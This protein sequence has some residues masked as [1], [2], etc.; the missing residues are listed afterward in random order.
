MRR[1][2]ILGIDPGERWLGVARAAGDNRLAFPLGSIDLSD[3]AADPAA[4]VRGLLDGDEVTTVVVGVPVRADGAED[5]QAARFRRFGEALAAQL[6]AECR[7]QSERH[8]SL[9]DA[10]PPAPPAP[11]A[12]GKQRRKQRPTPAQRRRERRESH[13]RAA[14]RILQR[15]LDAQPAAAG[16]SDMPSEAP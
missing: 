16:Q 5:E 6:G 11:H 7:P 8:S 2:C 1:R 12:R 15:W 13:A 3:A 9:D 4:A 14:A 10:A